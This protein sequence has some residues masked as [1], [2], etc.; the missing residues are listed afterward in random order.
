[1]PELVRDAMVRRPKTLPVSATVA[2]LRA[3]FANP[4]VRAA[5]LT[6]GTAFAGTIAPE[7]LPAD[8][9]DS[10]PVTDYARSDVER[11]T[12]D[13]P[14]AD[15]RAWLDA[16]DETRLVV[17]DDDGATLAGL[18]CLNKHRTGFCSD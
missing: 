6:D 4:K 15:A 8:A 10:A 9:P 13:A 12:P 16:A 11:T 17:I 3:L 2:D 1:M 18:L 5:L 7:E 14:L